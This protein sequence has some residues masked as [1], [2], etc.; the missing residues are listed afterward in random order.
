MLYYVTLLVNQYTIGQNA[1]RV[2]FVRYSDQGSVIFNLSRYGDANSVTTAIRS[3][4]QISGGSNLAAALDVVRTQVFV[5]S[6]AR[7]NVWKLAIVVTDQLQ[8]SQ[9]L[10]QAINNLRAD[11]SFR[12][13]AVGI[14]VSGRQ[15]DTNALS[16]Y[17]VTSVQG[18]SQLLNA[19][20]PL[21]SCICLTGSVPGP[22]PGPGPGPAPNLVYWGEFSV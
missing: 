17:Q 19:V 21:Q 11:S 8:Q 18:Y 13:C 4:Q 2:A 6:V 3:V 15:I 7:Q 14:V 16:P 12:L 5:S 10:T 20:Q 9:T 1:V 22:G